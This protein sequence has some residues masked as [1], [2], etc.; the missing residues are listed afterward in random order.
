MRV[1]RQTQTTSRYQY[2]DLR[3]VDLA[4]FHSDVCQ[5]PLYDFDESLSVDG[6]VQLFEGEMHRLLDKHAPL[7]SRCRRVGRNDW[8]VVGCHLQREMPRDAVVDSKDGSAEHTPLRTSQLP[9]LLEKS[10][11]TPSHSPGP[12][13]SK[14]SSVM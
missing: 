8:T 11:E 3:L 7:K 1:Q 2:R 13:P 6:Y 9:E 10:L 12:T 14:S 4:A 5:A